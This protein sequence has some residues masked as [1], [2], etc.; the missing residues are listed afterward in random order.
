MA[1]QVILTQKPAILT[2]GK[3]FTDQPLL[4]R[5]MNLEEYRAICPS[6]EIPVREKLFFRII[7]KTQLRHF[8]ALKTPSVEN[9]S[10]YK[11]PHCNSLLRIEPVLCV[12]HLI[13]LRFSSLDD[14]EQY[15]DDSDDQQ[16]M[17]KATN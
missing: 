5:G 16:Y 12:F 3:L 4:D 15:Q 17:D 6:P 9:L 1:K 7:Y 14:S 10:T 11:F 2:N 8:E 13:W